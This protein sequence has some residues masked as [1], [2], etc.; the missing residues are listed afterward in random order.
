MAISSSTLREYALVGARYRLDEIDKEKAAIERQFPE[1]N[2]G[3]G[4]YIDPNRVKKNG[5]P[6]VK[7]LYKAKAKAKGRKGKLAR[8]PGGP[9]GATSAGSMSQQL[10]DLATKLGGVTVDRAATE[11]GF[12]RKQAANLLQYLRKVKKLTSENGIFKVP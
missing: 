2:G 5:S 6:P 12:K 7:V 11:L 8:K 1:L 4:D 3:S 9:T 10:L